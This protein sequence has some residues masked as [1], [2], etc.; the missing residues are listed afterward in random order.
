MGKSRPV[1]DLRPWPACATWLVLPF[2][3]GPALA[4]ALEPRATGVRVVAT[5]LLWAGWVIGLVAALVPRTV[6]LTL[7]RSSLR[8]RWW[9]SDGRC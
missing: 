5:V 4:D 7:L 1:T 3:A 2:A 9:P 6:S 8:R